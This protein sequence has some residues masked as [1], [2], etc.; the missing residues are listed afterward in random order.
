MNGLTTSATFNGSWGVEQKPL[1]V[2]LYEIIDS[3]IDFIEL[4]TR[5]LLD[6]F[7]RKDAVTQAE[8]HHRT[9]A[10]NNYALPSMANILTTNVENEQ[11]FEHLEN[12]SRSLCILEHMKF[13]LRE[14]NAR[15]VMELLDDDKF[16]KFNDSQIEQVL[17]YL[18]AR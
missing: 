3:K 11:L 18:P 7:R 9:D 12:L 6:R 5:K 10:D 4:K 2:F 13:S 1:R 17:N 16:L 8:M 14:E 15:S